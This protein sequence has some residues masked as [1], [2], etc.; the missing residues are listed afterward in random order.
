MAKKW[1]TINQGIRYYE[2]ETRRQR[3]GRRDRYYAIRYCKEGK[4]KEE[5]LGWATEDWTV[6][7]AQAVLAKIKESIRTGVGPCSLEEM[8]Q[9]AIKKRAV[10]QANEEFNVTVAEFFDRYYVP[11]AQRRKR[12]WTHDVGRFDKGVRKRL[13]D[14]PIRAVTRE[15]VEKL[16]E[17]LRNEGLVESTILQYMAVLRQM[18]NL[19]KVT[20]I[21][22]VP[23]W[24]GSITP[25]NGVQLPG[26]SEE[27][28]RFLQVEEVDALI[29]AARTLPVDKK[30]LVHRD[31][32]VDLI[33]LAINTGL[34]FGELMRLQWADISLGNAFL[35]VR[36][37]QHRKPGGKV[38]LNRE[39]LQLLRERIAKRQRG[40]PHVFSQNIAGK[41]GCIFRRLYAMAVEAAELNKDSTNFRDKVVFHTLRHTFGSW[42]ALAYIPHKDSHAS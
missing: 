19:A 28:E 29:E 15:H 41:D 39:V 36:V 40:E 10:N 22:G 17:D 9:A 7:K 8:R 33:K 34:R 11:A 1:I 38:P 24:N 14:I 35:T 18:F 12:T 3:N 4:R 6:E 5:G 23:L 21:D 27:R 26:A 37:E 32:L 20:L 31:D 30:Y 2:H 13:G 25:I 16:M 42:L